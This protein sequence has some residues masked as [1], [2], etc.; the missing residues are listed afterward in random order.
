MWIAKKLRNLW[1]RGCDIKMIYAVSSRPVISILRNGSGRGRI[2]LRQSVITN[3]KREIVKYNHSK[4]MTITGRYGTS[5]GAWMTMSGSA[6]WSIF[7]FTGDE[8]VQTINSRNQ[9]LRH[10]NAFNIT[11][12]QKSSH[13]PGYGIK[14]SEARMTEAQ[15]IA[16]IP[17]E[18]TWGRGI[19]KY[20]SPAG[21]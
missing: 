1:N 3:K 11:W 8:Q 19:Y 6:N 15:R 17:A 16:L 5:T 20:L 13:A 21:E 2:P 4:W 18:P 10:I 14:G 7:A 9:A 12:S